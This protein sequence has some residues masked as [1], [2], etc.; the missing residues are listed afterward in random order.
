[1]V[2][3]GPSPGADR[4]PRDQHCRGRGVPGGGRDHPPPPVGRGTGG[5]KA[6]QTEDP[7]VTTATLPAPLRTVAMAR[8]RILIIEDERGLT[9]VLAY[10][11][12]REGYDTAVAHD[13]LEGL[14]KAQMQL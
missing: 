3:R 9:D 5:L 2:L 1:D 4:R 6:M 12:Q 11:L 8:P 10:N 14:R 7:S 13:G